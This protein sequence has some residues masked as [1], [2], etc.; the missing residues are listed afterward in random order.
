M[1]TINKIMEHSQLLQINSLLN[2]CNHNEL[3][4]IH[5][6]LSNRLKCI[7]CH[8]LCENTKYKCCICLDMRLNLSP[9]GIPQYCDGKTIKYISKEEHYCPIC[10]Q[11]FKK[12]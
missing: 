2:M 9:K 8:H 5:L 3:Q 12:T 1:T 10:K 4:K 7:E 6:F 11:N